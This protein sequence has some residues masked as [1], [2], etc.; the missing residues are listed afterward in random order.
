MSLP[1][2]YFDALYASA[3]DP[4]GFTSRWYEQRKYALTLASLPRRRY[5]S[6]FEPGCSIGVLSAR[7]ALRCDAL[8]SADVA[9]R[10]LSATRARVPG[11]VRV[12]RRQLPGD[13]PDEPFD[14]VV[15]SEVGYY[16]DAAGLAALVAATASGL[17]PG[18]DLVL[19]HWRHRVGDY[20]LTGDA[21]HDAFRA[22]PRLAPTVS[23]VED[24]FRLE[25]FGRVPPAARSVA[26]REGLC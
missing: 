15:L 18:G 2:A 1:P 12:Q 8:L 11:N 4:W 14:L 22:E 5:R 6:A 17:E 13:W 19:V 26:A 10:A 25:V 21:V 23:H 7:L 20:P 24:D 16:L 3:E 9:E